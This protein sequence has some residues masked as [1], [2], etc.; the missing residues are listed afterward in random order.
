MQELNCIATVHI[1]KYSYLGLLCGNASYDGSIL[2]LHGIHSIAYGNAS[3]GIQDSLKW[4][5]ASYR[6]DP[7]F[8]RA[9]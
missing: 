8:K 3:Y 1:Q 7:G 9:R 4:T 6:L 5:N 2:C